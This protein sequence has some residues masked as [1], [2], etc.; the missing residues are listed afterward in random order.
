M[1][2]LYPK[3]HLQ[4]WIIKLLCYIW[5]SFIHIDLSEKYYRI[6]DMGFFPTY[7]SFVC[8]KWLHIDLLG[9][10]RIYVF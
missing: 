3:R 5:L 2:D 1:L 7:S 6:I 10:T 4:K 8:G 9:V